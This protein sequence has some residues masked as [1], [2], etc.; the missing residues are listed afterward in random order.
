MAGSV[1]LFGCECSV[2]NASKFDAGLFISKA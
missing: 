2:T 1:E